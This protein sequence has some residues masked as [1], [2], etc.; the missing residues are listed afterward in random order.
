MAKGEKG[1]IKIRYFEVDLEGTDDTLQEVLRSVTSVVGR[2]QTTIV[3]TV[4]ALPSD[5]N[6]NG[7]EVI[8][9]LEEESHTPEAEET[10][11]PTTAKKA[12]QQKSFPTPKVLT[13][14]LKGGEM[15]FETFCQSKKPTDTTKKYLVCAAWLKEYGG[16]EEITADHIYT[17]FRAAH[18]SVQKDMGQTLRSGKKRGYYDNG[19]KPGLWKITHIGLDVVE[20]MGAGL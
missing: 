2:N 4:P 3:R 5:N 12:K 14:D 8:T 9:Y 10:P 20:K 15:P 17:C 6:Q 7:Q 13:I 1:K 19:S 18:W 11:V 16:L